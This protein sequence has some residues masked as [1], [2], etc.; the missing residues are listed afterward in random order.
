MSG[1]WVDEGMSLHMCSLFERM[2]HMHSQR[3]QLETLTV[4]QPWCQS[5]QAA[6]MFATLLVY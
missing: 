2:S 6:V 3:I 1:L 5:R 4:L